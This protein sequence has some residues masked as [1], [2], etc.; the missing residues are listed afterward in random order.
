M[1]TEQ[2]SMFANIGSTFESVVE[3]A[4]EVGNAAAAKAST[5]GSQPQVLCQSHFFR[6]SSKVRPN[7]SKSKSAGGGSQPQIIATQG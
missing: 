7:R 1:S 5:G 3:K 4:Q 6:R 2:N